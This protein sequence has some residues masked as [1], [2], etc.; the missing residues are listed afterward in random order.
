MTLRIT[1]AQHN[2]AEA[3]RTTSDSKKNGP[4]NVH[5]ITEKERK[6]WLRLNETLF[7][8]IFG[9]EKNNFLMVIKLCKNAGEAWML[10]LVA[11]VQI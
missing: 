3:V 7:W 2:D 9:F 10:S 1:D 5:C 11:D 4:L 8:I 6:K